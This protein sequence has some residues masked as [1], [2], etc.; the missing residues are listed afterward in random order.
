M[1]S[2]LNAAVNVITIAIMCHQANK[3]WCEQNGDFSQKDWNEAEEWQRESAIKG[4]EFRIANP[5]AGDD[6]QHNAWMKDKIENGWKYGEVKDAVAKTHPCL[7]PFEN[8]PEFQQKKDKIFAAVCDALL[9]AKEQ[10]ETFGTKAVGLSFNHAQ[11]QTKDAVHTCK[12]GFA[13]LIDQMDEFRNNPE[14]SQGAKRH[15]SAAITEIETAQMR[16][17]KALTWRD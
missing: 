6:A 15:A 17:V 12:L 3:V 11:G 2:N 5:N 1:N 9:P 8:L 14:T 16:A 13:N 4:V 7:V 10:K